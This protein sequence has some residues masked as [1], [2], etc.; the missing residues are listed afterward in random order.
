[1]LGLALGLAE[2]EGLTEGDKLG[3]PPSEGLALGETLG[4]PLGLAD[5]DKLGD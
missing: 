2:A 1:M 3:L 4:L 5:G